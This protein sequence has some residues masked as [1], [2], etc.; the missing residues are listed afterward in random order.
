MK[1]PPI[2][3]KFINDFK[4]DNQTVDVDFFDFEKIQEL[5]ETEYLTIRQRPPE[6][7]SFTVVENLLRKNEPFKARVFTCYAKELA[8]NYNDYKERLFQANVRYFLGKDQA[9]T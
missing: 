8:K 6:K 2:D 9:L 3:L 1:T 4:K 5:Y 7:I